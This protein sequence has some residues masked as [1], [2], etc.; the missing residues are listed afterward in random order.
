M[1]NKE[2]IE[3]EL[4]VGHEFLDIMGLEFDD[5][6]NIDDGIP[7]ILE[8]QQ[9]AV[10]AVEEYLMSVLTNGE[11]YTWKIEKEDGSLCMHYAQT[12]LLEALTHIVDMIHQERRGCAIIQ[13]HKSMEIAMYHFQNNKKT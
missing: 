12:C 1:L 2:K 5:L 7:V 10:L 11:S 8:N 9:T 13:F 3:K 4:G 6:L